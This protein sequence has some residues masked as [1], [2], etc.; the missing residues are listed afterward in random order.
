MED[1]LNA[2]DRAL[3]IVPDS[4]DVLDVRAGALQALAR[5]DEA[6]ATYD[7]MLATGQPDADTLNNHARL[8]LERGRYED[9]LRS[10]EKALTIKPEHVGALN[11]R[12][13]ALRQLG[14]PDAALLDLDRAIALA[15]R[16]T[17]SLVNK[18]TALVDLGRHSD[19]LESYDEALTSAPDCADAHFNAAM[20]RLSL[21]DFHAGWREYEWRWSTRQLA[22]HRRPFPQPLWLGKD[23]LYGKTIL[24]HA[25][26][27]LGDTIQFSRYVD[28]VAEQA[29]RIILEIQPSLM[30]LMVGF[31]NRCSIVA[32]GQSLPYFDVHCPLAS[33]PLAFDTDL[34]T[35]PASAPLQVPADRL[36][37]WKRHFA[38]IR[39]PKVGIVW[40]GRAAHDN[41]ANRSIR[42]TELSQLLTNSDVQFVSLQ[43]ELRRDDTAVLRAHPRVIHLGDN[44]EDFVDT[45]AVI[46]LLDVVIS[47]DTSVAHLA[48]ALG[49]PV[50]ILLPFAPDFRWMLEREDS[51][52][53]PSARLFRQPLRGDWDSVIA[54]VSA[55]MRTL[56]QKP[57][58]YARRESHAAL[59]MSA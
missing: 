7:R 40:A 11:N 19:A 49:K 52:W 12:G 5:D 6:L 48:G 31:A 8:L 28:R 30:R 47:V 24:L 35:V 25:E 22:P 23:A 38:D 55:E 45:A 2:C 54:R 3:A 51:P 50:F 17:E 16:H 53:Y 27:G 41:D 43:R 44:L 56:R 46:S 32:R 18:G 9:A 57:A 10:L 58:I 37:V 1:A 34:T 42:L 36:S 20:V 26:Q 59:A 13:A 21:G 4:L 39:K 33:L 29:S 15:P 14:R